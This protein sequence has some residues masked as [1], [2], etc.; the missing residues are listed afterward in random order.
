MA[1]VNGDRV[2]GC[3]DCLFLNVYVPICE[4]NRRLPVMFW[5][6]GGAFQ[7]G[8][9]NHADEKFIMDRDVVLVTINYRLGPFGF[10]STG[11]RVVPGN[12]GLKDQTMALRWVSE[13]IKY[14]GGNS[15]RVTIFGTSAGA[16]SVHYHY[17][18]S[19]S[20]GYFQRGISI[21]G[22]ALDPWSQTERAPQKTKK[23]ASLMGCP[24]CNNAKMIE[25]LR[26]RPA[27][28][29]SQAVG[30][31]MYWLYN[32]ATPFGPVIEKQKCP[33]PFIR[34]SPL[35]LIS[36][37]QVLDRPWITGVVSEE[38]LY[39]ASEFITNDERLDELNDHWD[40]IAPYL[41]D[42]NDTIPLSQ[43]KNVS[44][45]IREHYL[46]RESICSATVKP[47]V[48]MIGDRLFRVNFERA[49]RW[50]AKMNKSPVWAYYYT[51]RAK[52]SVSEFLSGTNENFGVCNGDDI[53][54]ILDARMA[55]T[56]NSEDIKMQQLL[57]DF[58]TSFAIHGEPKFGDATWKTTDP[59]DEEFCYLRVKNPSY[60][61]M[62]SSDNFA[63][64]AFWQTINFSENKFCSKKRNYSSWEIS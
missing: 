36:K 7:Y 34:R 17:L 60:V 23:L 11:D 64:K 53:F 39:S 50:Q 61:S 16:A 10:L 51:Y 9:G 2:A 49:V 45:R 54:L 27:R 63:Q 44:K 8:S 42:F 47:L 30:D 35:E 56:T 62:E 55:N 40:N 31:F 38:G 18:T 3:E 52:H 32:P 20:I 48:H 25:C 4:E 28:L 58:Y 12:M 57:L 22:V 24:T 13:N 37:G 26:E 1:P 46:G 41:L 6:H 15:K 14:F 59:E 33:R 43:Q 29:V 19:L 5:I 21:S